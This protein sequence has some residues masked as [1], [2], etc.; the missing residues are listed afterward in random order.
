MSG[1]IE[2][3]QELEA[4]YTRAPSEAALRK[5]ATRLTPLYRQW[6]SAARFCILSTVG[7]QGTDGS[8]RGDVGPVAV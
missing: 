7:P 8:P 3:V 6:I 5:V 2:T 4:L 1:Y